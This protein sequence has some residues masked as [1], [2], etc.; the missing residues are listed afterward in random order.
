MKV[1]GGRIDQLNEQAPAV[2]AAV[3]IVCT[4]LL[5]LE[6]YARGRR[7]I[8]GDSSANY[9]Y[10]AVMHGQRARWG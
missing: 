4:K 2:R 9:I 6:Y 8:H 3:R 10:P 5:V 7:L 1:Y